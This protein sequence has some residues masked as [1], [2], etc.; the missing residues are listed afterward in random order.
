MELEHSQAVYGTDPK[1]S[2]MSS[3]SGRS[4]WRR[5]GDGRCTVITLEKRRRWTMYRDHSGEETAMDD[6]Q[7][8]L[9]RRDGD[10]R[11]T[12]IT[13]EKRRRWT[14]YRDHSGEETAMDDVQ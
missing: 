8:S 11:C 4:L 2:K 3:T 6:V 12:E 14:M 13:L 1:D 7:R 9:W 10:G 5:D